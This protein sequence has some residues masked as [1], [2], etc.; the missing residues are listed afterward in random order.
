VFQEPPD[1]AAQQEPLDLAD[2]QEPRDH[3]AHQDLMVIGTRQ[4]VLII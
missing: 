1:L 4:P 3:L 2:Q